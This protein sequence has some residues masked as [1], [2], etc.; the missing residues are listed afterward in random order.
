MTSF[1]DCQLGPFETWSLLQAAMIKKGS[2]KDSAKH[3]S[4]ARCL[5]R[6][7]LAILEK[8]SSSE[9][10][11]QQFNDR[12]VCGSYRTSTEQRHVGAITVSHILRCNAGSSGTRGALLLNENKK[13]DM[14]SNDWLGFSRNCGCYLEFF[15]LSYVVSQAK[16]QFH[17]NPPLASMS[18]TIQPHHPGSLLPRLLVTQ[19]PLLASISFGSLSAGLPPSLEPCS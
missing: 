3:R 1:A 5:A 13:N 14:A 6:C 17:E 7:N 4:H 2:T 15:L 12:E 19:L 8:C 11:R 16:G 10:E 9:R 18:N